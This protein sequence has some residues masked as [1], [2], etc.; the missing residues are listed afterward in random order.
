MNNKHTTIFLILITTLFMFSVYP[1]LIFMLIMVLLGI[2]TWIII[3]KCFMSDKPESD[4]CPVIDD[5]PDHD[6]NEHKLND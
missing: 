6:L 5:K 3:Y 2:V 1:N 4:K